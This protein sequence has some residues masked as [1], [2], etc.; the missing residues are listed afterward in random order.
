MAKVVAIREWC[1]PERN[2]LAAGI[3]SEG[4]DI[5]AGF[6]GRITA[7]EIIGSAIFLKNNDYMFEG[8]GL[9]PCGAGTESQKK[10]GKNP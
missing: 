9:C 5:D 2:F 8:Y 7:E 4:S 3:N 10:Q 1:R 6:E